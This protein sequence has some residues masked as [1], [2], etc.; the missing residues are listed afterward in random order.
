[1][2]RR[3][4]DGNA[5]GFD[6]DVKT[7]KEMILRNDHPE[8]MFISM[9]GE[10]GSG[11][12]TLTSVL[13]KKLGEEYFTVFLFFITPYMRTEDLLQEIH[14]QVKEH[15]TEEEKTACDK[16][17]EDID[18]AGKIRYLLAK[19]KMRYLLTLGGVSSKTMLNCVRACLPDCN[20]GSSVLLVL[21][22]ENEEVAWYANTMNK[23]SSN[24]IHLV[25]RLDEGRSRQLFCWRALRREV[26]DGKENMSMYGKVVY[27]ITGGHPL[28]VVLLAGLLRFKEK[29]QQWEVVLQQIMPGPGTEEGKDG[30]G[31][32]KPARAADLPTRTAIERI[33]WA[34]FEDLPNDLK[35]CFL[36]FAVIP[37]STLIDAS[38]IVRMWIGE[39]FIKPQKGRTMEELGHDYLK[40]LALRCLV[41]IGSTNTVGSIKRVGVHRSLHGF[42]QSEAREAGLIEVHDIHD[43]FVPPSARRLCLQTN[44][45]RYTTF[46]NK[47]HKLRSFICIGNKAEDPIKD[48]TGK[49]KVLYDLKFLLGSKFL[50]LIV[51]QGPR[52]KELP[53]EIGNMMHL[54]HLTVDS[55]DLTDL[56]P[57]IRGLLNLQTLYIKNTNVQK[58]DPGFWKIKTLRHVIAAKLTLP[59]TLPEELGE[60]Q[61]LHGVMP[62]EGMGWDQH[63]CPLHKMTKL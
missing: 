30:E 53:K 18:I 2:N 58:I 25:S 46:T 16:E 27:D 36:Y 54:R 21:D 51:V 19:T 23:D 31:E 63:N 28:S 22:T 44:G 4:D 38:E 61:T 49:N 26:S 15:C 8:L 48:S 52:I 47:F 40:E 59:E 1:M 7:L 14:R 55:N 10:S 37:K 43:A 6:E 11:K 45:G 57:S 24:K 13:V 17:V 62:A 12:R 5:V 32:M 3:D 9:F 34:S 35:S 60:L 41:R 42:L 29:P 56:P 20:T 39:G 50:R 33:F